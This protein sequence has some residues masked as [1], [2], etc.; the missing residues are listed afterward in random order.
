MDG[1]DPLNELSLISKYGF[2]PFQ[3]SITPLDIFPEVYL[4]AASNIP[5]IQD[6]DTVPFNL[7]V[8]SPITTS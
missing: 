3:P 8:L 6:G 7:F 2:T 1:N 5:Y 4:V